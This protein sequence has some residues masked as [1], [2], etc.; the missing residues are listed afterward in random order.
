MCGICGIVDIESNR[1]IDQELLVSI[2]DTMVHRGPDESGT[3][4]DG[5]LG[6]GHRRLSIIDVKSGQQPF[7]N[8][9]GTTTVTYNGEIY[10]FRAVASELKLLGY[11]FRTNSDTEVIVHAWDEWG[12]SC[13]D[14]FRGMFAFAIWDK[15]SDTLFLARDRLGIKPLF[16]GTTE[17]GYF[18]FAS[19][20]K[21]LRAHP[22]ISQELNGDSIVNYFTF[23]YVPAPDSIYKSVKKLSAGHTLTVKKGV[24]Q[25]P[26]E[27][28]DVPLAIDNVERDYKNTKAQLV[29]RLKEAVELRM[30]AEVPL[31]AFLS[32]G[33]D[34]STVVS[35]MSELQDEALHTCSIGFEQSNFNESH[36]AELVADKFGTQHSAL[37]VDGENIDLVSQLA[38]IYDEPFSDSSAIPTV[39]LCEL[40]R[41]KVTVALSGDG[42]DELLVGYRRQRL[43][44]LEER[45]RNL[46]PSFIKR[47]LIVPLG[48]IYP[49]A[50]WAP[51][52]FRAK[53]TLQ[54]LGADSITA[55]LNSVS[56][57]SPEQRDLIFSADFKR[58][59]NLNCAR[60]VFARHAKKANTKDPML[61]MQ[62][63]DIKTYLEGDILTKVD[64]AS[65]AHSLE[66]RVPFLDHILLDWLMRLPK[67]NK[68]SKGQGKRVLKDAMRSRLD[69]KLLFRNKM[70]FS[71]PLNVWT[72][73]PLN[74]SVHDALNNIKLKETGIFDISQLKS[75][76]SA[77]ESG[78]SDYSNLFW[79]VLMFNNFLEL[80]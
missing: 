19:E 62:Y 31:G 70:G 76:L 64:R 33:V 3:Y 41:K 18:V 30:L 61:M 47:Y 69:T 32:G 58:N 13:V 16:Y 71:V 15:R 5:G 21:A 49:K 24:V 77:H 42:A 72:K 48:D 28:W 17:D 22:G 50:D 53:T 26:I 80:N 23:G 34:S 8:E 66:V 51:R 35:L 78:H 36:F 65:M 39:R 2:R 55:Y 38:A 40:A 45:F 27:Y 7:S 46:I 67:D 43:H 74:Q 14:R 4:F 37:V 12:A 60:N 63:L 29:E 79:S 54:A 9:A 68:L 57:I 1:R 75:M 56:M 59:N 11:R 52:M 25:E 20:L 73:G 10:N 44:M 6:F